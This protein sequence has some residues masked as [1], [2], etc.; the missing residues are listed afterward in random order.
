MAAWFGRG[1]RLPGLGLAFKAELGS[2]YRVPSS[3]LN[4]FARIDG[5][6]HSP[7][8]E[9]RTMLAE[10]QG[11]GIRGPSPH[12]PTIDPPLAYAKSLSVPY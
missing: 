5:P 1:G 11:T 6:L 8:I 12:R 4:S 7:L 2:K 9:W 10:H 3:P